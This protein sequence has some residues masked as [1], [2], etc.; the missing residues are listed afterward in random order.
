MKTTKTLLLGSILL[1]AAFAG[2]LALA[3][4][5]AEVETRLRAAGYAELRELE[6]DSGL[7]DAEVRRAD[8]RW[9]DIA[10]DPASD[11]I[12]DGRDGRAQL[13]LT[14]IANALATAGYTAVSDLE[15]DGALWDAEATGPDGQRVDLRISAYDGRIVTSEPEDDQDD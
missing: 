8:G 7:W 9:G 13:D 1:G 6:F 14:A 11:E 15:R 12:F 3:A 5:P 10:Y 4:G 2:G